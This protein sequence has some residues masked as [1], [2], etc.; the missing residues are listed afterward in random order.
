MLADG[1][2]DVRKQLTSVKYDG[3]LSPEDKAAKF[4]AW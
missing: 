1:T 4:D 3:A 2:E